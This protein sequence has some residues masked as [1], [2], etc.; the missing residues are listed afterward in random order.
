MRVTSRVK[1]VFQVDGIVTAALPL[2]PLNSEPERFSTRCPWK[3]NE[4]GNGLAEAFPLSNNIAATDN[5]A[6]TR[7]PERTGMIGNAGS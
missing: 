5:A 1:V 7:P 4:S 3:L 6:R 2:M